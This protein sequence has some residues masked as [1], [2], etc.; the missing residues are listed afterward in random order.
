MKHKLK[1]ECEDILRRLITSHSFLQP[2][3][4][5]YDVWD[6]KDAKEVVADLI[7]MLNASSE[8]QDAHSKDGWGKPKEKRK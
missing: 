1:H 4:P 8:I 6:G 2:D 5:K 7:E 3:N